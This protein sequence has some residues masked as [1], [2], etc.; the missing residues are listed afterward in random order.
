MTGRNAGSL[1]RSFLLASVFNLERVAMTIDIDEI[2]GKA[3]SEHAKTCKGKKDHRTFD[4][5]PLNI[6]QTICN[7]TGVLG[8]MSAYEATRAFG[9]LMVM[10]EQ[11]TELAG[12]LNT[13]ADRILSIAPIQD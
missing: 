9:K 12:A 11:D 10:R 6:L 1:G 5:L 13:L 2:I 4:D 7:D 3:M 8:P